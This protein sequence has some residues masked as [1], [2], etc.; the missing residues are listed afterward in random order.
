VY[1]PASVAGKPIPIPQPKA[2]LSDTEYPVEDGSEEGL[3][4]DELLDVVVLLDTGLLL[5]TGALLEVVVLI[6][7]PPS[8]LMVVS[9]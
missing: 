7:C 4:V 6:G 9:R 2:I 3:V 8:A 5:D 1:N